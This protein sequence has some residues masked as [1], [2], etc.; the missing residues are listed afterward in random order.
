MTTEAMN[1]HQATSEL[2]LAKGGTLIKQIRHTQHQAPHMSVVLP[3]PT[4]F[5]QITQLSGPQAND[6]QGWSSY[7]MMKA[8]YITTKSS[9]R[10]LDRGKR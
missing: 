1:K 4:Y 6:S 3:L 9:L 5:A 8:V 10:V 2:S 7:F